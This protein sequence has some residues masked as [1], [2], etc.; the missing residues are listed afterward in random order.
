MDSSP[1]FLPHPLFLPRSRLIPFSYPFSY[2]FFLPTFMAVDPHKHIAVVHV[3]MVFFIALAFAGLGTTGCASAQTFGGHTFGSIRSLAVDKNEK[4][5]A[6]GGEDGRVILWSI[7]SGAKRVLLPNHSVVSSDVHSGYVL[8]GEDGQL[9]SLNSRDQVAVQAVHFSS[10]S[11]TLVVFAGVISSYELTTGS[12]LH[13]WD[14]PAD[15]NYS[16]GLAKP[17]IA[18]NGAVV[19]SLW[20]KGSE[21][22]DLFARVIETDSGR[23]ILNANV[24]EL[25]PRALFMDANGHVFAAIGEGGIKVWELPGGH[26]RFERGAREATLRDGVFLPDRGT[27][28]AIDDE[29]KVTATDPG[30]GRD[31]WE[32]SLRNALRGD[33]ASRA[34]FASITLSPD[35]ETVAAGLGWTIVLINGRTGEELRRIQLASNKEG[36]S[37]SVIGFA[38]PT[39]LVLTDG[40]R[41]R[42]FDIT[43]GKEVWRSARFDGGVSAGVVSPG[44][45]F[46][47]VGGGTAEVRPV[48]HVFNQLR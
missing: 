9:L 12:E 17:Y 38:G 10:K 23:C 27:I 37:Q 43:T 41:L 33:V 21:T 3:T 46:A 15:L 42:S 13:R 40:E 22:E 6:S 24:A 14:P 39:R 11:E 48:V 31:L 5:L 30:L 29:W 18:D 19:A 44:G 26:I 45:N 2:P 47:A 16:C 34:F 25:R 28:V 20:C 1:L 35:N 32:L 4:W 8:R 36:P 7:S